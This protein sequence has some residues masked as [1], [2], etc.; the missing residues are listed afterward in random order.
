[1]RDIKSAMSEADALLNQLTKTL[2]GS[3]GTPAGLTIAISQ[4][5]L[6]ALTSFQSAGMSED[7]LRK[8]VA[9]MDAAQA[10]A[11]RDFSDAPGMETLQ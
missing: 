5:Y 3:E 7:G 9:I 2:E 8:C 11:K 6:L 4:L 10:V 1:M